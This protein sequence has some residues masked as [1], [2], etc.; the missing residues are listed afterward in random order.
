M[1]KMLLKAQK[2]MNAED[3]LAAI[4]EESMPK[5]RESAKEDWRGRK[6]ERKDCQTSFDESKQSDKKI[7]WTE[8][9]TPLVMLVNNILV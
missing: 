3:A 5:E 4:G 1:A 8:K 7:P 2:Y 9:F 6:R